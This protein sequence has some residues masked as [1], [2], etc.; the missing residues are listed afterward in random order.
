MR[1]SGQSRCPR[2]EIALPCPA[3]VT[4]TRGMRRFL[5][6]LAF[7][8]M[9]APATSAEVF[10]LVGG[11]RLVGE[12]VNRH[13]S[14]RRT[15]VI[16]T[17]DGATVTLDAPQVQ[18]MLPQRPEEAE[19]DRIRPTYPDTA[20]AQW[21]LAEWCRQH[22]LLTQREVHLGRVIELD[23]EHVEARRALG[24]TRV[25]GQWTTQD[26]LMTK[27][28]YVRYKGAWKTRQ[29]VELLKNKREL[30]TAQ[31]EWLQNFKRW[32]GWLGTDR[33][34]Q[35]RD[36]IQA[37]AD[38]AAIKAL[39]KALRDDA[40]PGVRLLVIGALAK[41]DTLDAAKALA[42]ASLFDPVEE[43]RLTCLDR[44]QTAKWPEVVAYYIGKLRDK[45]STN[46]VVNLAGFALGRMKDPSAVGPLIDALI[47]VHKFKL[48]KPGGDNSTTGSF[49][50]GPGQRGTGL[51]TGGKPT[52]I[53]KSFS[54]QAVLDA[55]VAL[56]GKNF[57]FDQPAWKH[58]FASQKKPPDVI[59]G[60]RD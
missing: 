40:D 21:E 35:A 60:R 13:E 19:Y 27:R 49:G 51:S 58:W 59:N 15:Y 37:I 30:E 48:E 24:Y 5:A 39:A 38:P 53:S 42:I 28:G 14:P 41:I 32:R 16:R 46:E 47:T 7:L 3:P 22:K 44:L 9:V 36:N 17:A 26:E 20:A 12:L 50:G 10:V 25:D 57:N 31:Q 29:E 1:N 52:I 23:P 2:G 56:T 34:Q 18:K 4:Y 11:G 33:D 54:N 45:K 8:S 6:L 55:L 43:V